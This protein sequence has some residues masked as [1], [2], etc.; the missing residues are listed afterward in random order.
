MRRRTTFP[1]CVTQVAAG[2]PSRRR[3]P[4]RTNKRVLE[5]LVTSDVQ[6]R[7]ESLT[8]IVE[9][10]VPELVQAAPSLC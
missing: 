3:T 10:L 8:Q 9:L 7:R 6:A 5:A 4:S 1:R 2:L